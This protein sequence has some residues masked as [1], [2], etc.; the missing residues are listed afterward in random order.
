MNW[1]NLAV[2]IVLVVLALIVPSDTP[3]VGTKAWKGMMWFLAIG[4]FAV[5]FI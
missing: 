2:G 5:I 3:I 1:I 4:N